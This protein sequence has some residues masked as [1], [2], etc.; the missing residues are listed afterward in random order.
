LGAGEVGAEAGKAKADGGKAPDRAH[1]KLH[2]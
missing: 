1:R 2:E